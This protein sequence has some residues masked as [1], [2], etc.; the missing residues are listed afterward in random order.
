VE[1]Q[2]VGAAADL[3]ANVEI[4]RRWEAELDRSRAELEE[5]N[6]KLRQALEEARELAEKAQEASRAK[7]Q[8]LAMM[9]HE[10]RTP[11]NGVMGMA[12]GIRRGDRRERQQ[13]P[14][15]HRRHS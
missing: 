6:R 12:E 13:P 4:R 11:M 14:L 8:F 10:I 5:S 15:H 3:L 9:S 2:L 7:S 1:A